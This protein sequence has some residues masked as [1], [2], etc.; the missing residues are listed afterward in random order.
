M[1][2]HTKIAQN[3]M[4]YLLC[5]RAFLWI[6]SFPFPCIKEQRLHAVLYTFSHGIT[7]IF[8]V[9]QFFISPIEQQDDSSDFSETSDISTG[10]EIFLQST[11]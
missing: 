11:A 7:P 10:W 2:K 4:N 6:L 3:P 1:L 8:P 9:F 5:N